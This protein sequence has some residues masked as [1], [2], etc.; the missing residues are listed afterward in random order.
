MKPSRYLPGAVF[1]GEM[2]SCDDN[3]ETV[4]L[5]LRVYLDKL[6]LLRLASTFLIA[7]SLISAL[8]GIASKFASA[9]LKVTR[10]A[11]P[12][13]APTAS[14]FVVLSLTKGSLRLSTLQL[15]L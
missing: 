10:L 5:L 3:P 8:I 9:L 2:A 12:H 1:K 4:T 13:I 15:V 11:S 6:L 14:S 7:L